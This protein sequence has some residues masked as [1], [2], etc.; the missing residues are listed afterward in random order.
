[1][2]NFMPT[3]LHAL[4]PLI[5]EPRPGPTPLDIATFSYEDRRAIFP[6]V[7]EA[8]ELCGCWLLDR[9]Q[10]S[11]TQVEFHFEL[12]LRSVLD[13]YAALIAA[14]LELTRASHEH[15]TVLWT[16]RRH[17][18]CPNGLSGVV[19]VCLL[20]NFLEDGDPI[21]GMAIGAASA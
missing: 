8:L 16:L 13:L 17:E 9:R 2:M 21:Y 1:M 6:A 12:Q 3:D 15:L 20:V 11:L 19:T 14:G 7:A 4:P 5:A 10:T 18:D